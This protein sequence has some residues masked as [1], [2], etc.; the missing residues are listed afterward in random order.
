MSSTNQAIE[1]ELLKEKGKKRDEKMY[2]LPREI[3]DEIARTK[4]SSIQIEI[5]ELTEEQKKYL[6]S[7]EIGT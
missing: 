1:A 5:D 6:A 4:L 2:K 3:E 7:W